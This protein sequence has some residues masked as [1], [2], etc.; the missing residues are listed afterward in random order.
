MPQNQSLADAEREADALR[1][2]LHS[3]TRYYD[4]VVVSLQQNTGSNNAEY[5]A[6]MINQLS[7]L[8]RE[9]RAI[10]TELREKDA[11]I[12]THQ[13]AI[14]QLMCITRPSNQAKKGRDRA[15]FV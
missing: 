4:N 12:A 8:D 15:L 13:K 2:R 14:K 10:M 7:F 3:V 5:E 6:D 9:K 1:T 11:M